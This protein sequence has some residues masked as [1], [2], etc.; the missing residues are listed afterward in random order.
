MT[1]L[2]PHRRSSSGRARAGRKLMCGGIVATIVLIALTSVLTLAFLRQQAQERM[3]AGTRNLAR[4]ITITFDGLIDGI[5]LSLLASADEIARQRASGAASSD[6][7]A[8]LLRQQRRLA[9]AAVLSATSAAGQIVHGAGRG[10]RF[11]ALAVRSS[12]LQASSPAQGADGRWRWFFARAIS[13]AGALHD[14]AVIGA[15][16]VVQLERIMARIHLDAGGSIVLRNAG[17]EAIAARLGGPGAMPLRP[18]DTRLSPELRIALMADPERGTYSTRRSALSDSE[19]TFSYERSAKYG[20]YVSV[21]EAK[22]MGMAEWERQMWII[23]ALMLAFTVLAGVLLMLMRRA[24]RRQTRYLGEIRRLAYHCCLTGLPNRGLVLDRLSACM[25]GSA[26][27]RCSGALMIIDL[28][29]FKNFNDLHGYERGDQLLREV[30]RRLRASM[31]ES[32]T[33][34]RLGGDEFALLATALPRDPGQAR[35]QAE[36]IGDILRQCLAGC[37][38]LD[39]FQ[40]NGSASIGIALFTEQDHSRDELVKRAETAVYQAKAA[41]RNAVRF[42]DADMQAALAE[43]LALERDL[44]LAQDADQFELHYQV[45]VG[46]NGAIRGAE[47]LLRWHHPQRGMVAPEEFIAVA[48]QSGL[49]V[50]IGRWVLQTACKQLVRWAQDPLAAHL[51]LAVN[52]SACQLSQPGFVTEVLNVLASTGAE[53]HRLKLELTEGVLIEHTDGIIATIME[54]KRA[55]VGISL[56]DFGTGYSSLSYLKRLPLDQLKIDQSFVRDLLTDPTDRAIV[57][58]IV[59]LGYSLDMDVI[60]EGVESAAQRDALAAAGCH[61]YQGYFFGKPLPIRQF[62]AALCVAAVEELACLL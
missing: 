19:H 61:A 52:V 8:F 15:L 17:F 60:A 57:L 36:L 38:A 7:D 24:W 32:M 16:D 14:G 11:D 2:P 12:A 40:Y 18:G 3:D 10:G 47:A 39:G 59:A 33:V 30:A 26:G 23:S 62:D 35:V 27:R 9:A 58:A 13:K 56:D 22:A 54:L 20:F 53:P 51:S 4:S 50:P 31:P 41:G 34:A 45:Q 43:R 28:D 42:F 5:D 49:I 55:G 29:Q 25:A 48:E 21:G 1:V 37:Y 44:R 6:I 46:G